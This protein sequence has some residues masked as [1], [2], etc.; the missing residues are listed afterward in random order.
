SESELKSEPKIQISSSQL[1]NNDY[2]PFGI[3]IAEID[4]MLAN[5]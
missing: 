3:E 4:S 1:K 5:F 2:D